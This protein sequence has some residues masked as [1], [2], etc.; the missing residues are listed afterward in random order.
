[1]ESDKV[2]TSMAWLDITQPA[3]HSVNWIII[4]IAAGAIIMVTLINLSLLQQGYAMSSV[5]NRRAVS[6]SDSGVIAVLS[7]NHLNSAIPTTRKPTVHSS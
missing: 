4:A 7:R 3:G 6:D 1:M 2:W 5:M